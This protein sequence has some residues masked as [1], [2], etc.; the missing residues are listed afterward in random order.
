[1]RVAIS[2]PGLIETHPTGAS[3]CA[4]CRLQDTVLRWLPVTHNKAVDAAAVAAAEGDSP[5]KAVLR[6]KGFMWLSN[7]HTTAFYWSH[8]GKRPAVILFAHQHIHTPC[9]VT[10]YHQ[11]T[12][13][14]LS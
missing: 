6:S 5:I 13:S 7:K 14:L 10:I 4:V 1:M 3:T 12:L 9:M 8:A 2:L 11:D